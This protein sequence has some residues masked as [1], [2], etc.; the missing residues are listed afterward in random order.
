MT[1]KMINVRL[2]KRKMTFNLTSTYWIVP[3]IGMLNTSKHTYTHNQK[4]KKTNKNKK[5]IDPLLK[6]L[7]NVQF[8]KSEST[9]TCIS[10]CLH[11]YH[12]QHVHIS[13][14]TKSIFVNVLIVKPNSPKFTT[15]I[16][17]I[18]I[19]GDWHFR[20]NSLKL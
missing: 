17:V 20:T 1:F 18:G 12:N 4:K 16:G 10:T 7:K 5:P 9:W 2:V 14:R 19:G 3:K 8:S 6:N 15:K 11:K 13:W